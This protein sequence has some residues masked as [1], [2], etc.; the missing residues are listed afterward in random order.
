MAAKNSGQN[1]SGSK[2]KQPE[3]VFGDG[4]IDDDGNAYIASFSTDSDLEDEPITRMWSYRRGTW[5]Y[6]DVDTI[7]QSAIRVSKPSPV[8]YALGRDGLISV[9]TAAGLKEERI[10]DA[11]TG[12]GKYGYV[13]RI[14]QIGGSLYVCGHAGQVYRRSSKGWTHIDTGV[15]RPSATV[16]GSIS[17]YDIHGSSEHDIYTAGLK[18][19]LFHYDGTTWSE[20][21]SPTNHHIERIECVSETEVYLCGGSEEEGFLFR[22]N[23]D[24]GWETFQT[25]AEGGFSGLTV[26]KGTP[27]VCAQ[28]GLWALQSNTLLQIVPDIEPEIWFFRLVSNDDVMWSIGHEDLATFDGSTWT[29][30]QHLDAE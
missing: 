19:I 12:K 6:R 3:I 30:I 27:Y 26:F 20:L 18:G 15:L 17:L 29:R 2:V 7:V 13:N 24:A 21:D 22:G 11:G 23:K 28:Q 14:R 4:G 16:K 10:A 1:V 8:G 5:L 9:A 25:K